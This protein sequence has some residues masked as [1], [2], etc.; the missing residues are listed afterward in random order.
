M[1]ASELEASVER[2]NTALT[3][4]QVA[5]ERLKAT[6]PLEEQERAMAVTRIDQAITAL[7]RV[8][9]EEGSNATSHS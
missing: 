1:H 9:G 5:A 3:G 2:F 7:R 4:L 6:K 8:L